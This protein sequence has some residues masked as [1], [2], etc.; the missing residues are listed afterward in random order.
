MAQIENSSAGVLKLRNSLNESIKKLKET[1]KKANQCVDDAKSYWD[2]H[3]Y[4]AFKKDFVE[5]VGVVTMLYKKMEEFDKKL[6][7]LQLKL[8][9]YEGQ[10]V[11]SG[12]KK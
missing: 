2:D 1:Q 7:D 12:F 10:K 11:K 4:A 8:T 6:S 5:G 9:Q 3:N